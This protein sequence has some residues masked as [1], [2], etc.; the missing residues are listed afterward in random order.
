L[1]PPWEVRW[2]ALP[3]LPLALT[4]WMGVLVYTARRLRAGAPRRSEAL[5]LVGVGASLI[6]GFLLTPF[7]SDPS[8]RYF[9]PLAVP[10]SL[11]AAELVVKLRERWGNWAFGLVGLVLAFNLIGTVQSA[12]KYPP[13][14]TTQFD[15]VAQLDHRYDGAL[16]AFLEEQGETRG[17]TNYWVAYPLAFKSREQL[18]FIPRLPYHQDF[19][20]TERDDRYAAYDEIVAQSDRVAYITTRHPDLNQRLRNSFSDLGAAWQEEQIGDYVVFYR[21][22]RGVRPDEIGL[23]K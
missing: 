14:I 3:I 21:L 17:Y 19:R 20:Y 4:F 2:L 9:L 5:L 6:A 7:G 18:I 22:S 12:L 10:M 8:G 11:F 13:G 1:R 23:G 16:I 15:A